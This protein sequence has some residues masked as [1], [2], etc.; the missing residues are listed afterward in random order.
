MF[1]RK[2]L[3]LALALGWMMCAAA[4]PGQPSKAPDAAPSAK[5][6]PSGPPPSGSPAPESLAL[7]RSLV[8]KSGGGGIMAMNGLSLPLSNLLK[9]LGVH[10]DQ[11]KLVMSQAIMPV[12]LDHGDD[13]TA[14]QA[15][16]YA[17]VLSVDTMKAAIAFYDSPAGK[18][19]VRARAPMMQM[20]MA[21]VSKLF[22]TLKPEFKA[23]TAQ[24]LA[25]H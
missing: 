11:S 23:R 9:Q 24:L 13:L 6:P 17:A 15:N 21:A 7:A 2:A 25:G 12:L 10:P 4:A 3:S 22:E 1:D 5:S 16:S 20:N 18:E 14:I 19:L 8:T